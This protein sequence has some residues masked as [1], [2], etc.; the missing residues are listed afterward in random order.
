MAFVIRGNLEALSDAKSTKDS[1]RM[2]GLN[3][4]LAI[5]DTEGA[6]YHVNYPTRIS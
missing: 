6:K 2:D 3:D 5:L 4:I 1:S